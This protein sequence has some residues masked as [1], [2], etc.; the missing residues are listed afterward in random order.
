MSIQPTTL[1]LEIPAE[2][3]QQDVWDLE[4]Q[5]RQIAGVTTDLQEP[6]DLITPTLLFF[7][8]VAPYVK[9]A[10]IIA[11]GLK[12]TR[13]VAQILYNFLHTDRKPGKNKVV[14]VKKGVRIELYNLSAQ[15]IEKVLKQEHHH[16]G[17]EDR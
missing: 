16:G 2:V 14:L 8:L 13:E 6:K 17:K 7:H 15:E 1:L 11:G 5:S 12:V 10:V 3:A 9:D 4:N